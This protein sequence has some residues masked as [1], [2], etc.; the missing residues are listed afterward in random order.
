MF[1]ACSSATL[2]LFLSFPFATAMHHNVPAMFIFGDS[3]AD[4]G[5]NNFIANTTAKANF[6]PYGETFFH[7]PTGRFTNGRTAFDFIGIFF[8]YL[9]AFSQLLIFNGCQILSLDDYIHLIFFISTATKLRLPFPPPYLNPQSDFSRGI[10][11][12]SGGSGLLDST[13]NCLVSAKIDT[14]SF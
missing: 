1:I 14:C 9:F 13:G 6:P 4:A 8:S 3:L 2:I 10:N 11:F 5:T 12:A 7:H